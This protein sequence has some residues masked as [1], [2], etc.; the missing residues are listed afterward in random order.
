MKKSIRVLIVDDDE[1]DFMIT[2]AI[3]NEIPNWEC[4]VEWAPS[5][6]EGIR[7][8]ERRNHDIYFVDYRLGMDDENGLSVIRESVKRGCNAPMIVLTG[9][10][11]PEIDEEGMKSGA[12]DFLVKGSFTASELERSIRYSLNHLKNIEKIRSLNAELERRV[13]ERTRG[14]HQVMVEL[15]LSKAETEEALR[16][17]KE[18]NELKSRFVTMASHEFRT[19][20]STILSSLDLILRYSA[21][22][23]LA[24]RTKHIDRIRVTIKNLT[25]LLDDFLSLGKLDGG[26]ITASPELFDL[27]PFCEQV[28]SE[29]QLLAKN[30]QIIH[31]QYLGT[32]TVVSMDPKIMKNILINLLSN[33]C[34]FSGEESEILFT[35]RNQGDRIEMIVKDQGIGIPENEQKHMFS[36]FFR[37]SNALNIQGTG[38]GLNIVL[39]YVEMMKGTISFASG[40]NGTAFTL[41]FP[42]N[43][44]EY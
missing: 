19:P 24:K 40:E 8:I 14:L 38:L 37:A 43:A 16:K 36:S 17:E 18:L 28:T 6:H 25:C 13:E 32:Q 33:A 31:Y 44:L 15:E 30:E 22:E 27:K 26:A 12:H 4:K 29:M 7:E 34:K 41:T 5:Y 1:E 9:Q 10:N 3:F 23:H 42:V 11:S 39:R 2:R 20:L 21:D 35:V